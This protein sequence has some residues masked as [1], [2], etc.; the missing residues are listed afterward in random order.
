MI[1]F[2][3]NLMYYYFT[4]WVMLNS[5]SFNN[6]KTYQLAVQMLVQCHVVLIL[7]AVSHQR[8]VAVFLLPPP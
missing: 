7:V 8:P 5:Y 4:S 1:T 2:T 3:V 6:V